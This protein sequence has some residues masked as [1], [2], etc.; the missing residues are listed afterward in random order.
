[1]PAG[2]PADVRLRGELRWGLELARLV[3]DPGFLRPARALDAPPVLLIPGFMAGD[4]SLAVLGGWL[5]KRGCATEAAGILLNMGCAE[6]VVARIETRLVRL[7]ERTGRR[8]V[9]VGQSRGGELARVIAVR[10]P[11]L[12][13]AL[14]MLGSPVLDPLDVGPITLAAVRWVARLGDVGVPGLFSNG[15]G[16]GECCARFREELV[17]PL[18]PAVRA[19]SIYSRSDGIVSWTACLD[20]YATTVEVESSHTGMAVNREVYHLLAGILDGH[21]PAPAAPAQ[22]A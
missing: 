8:V 5:R 20:P 6:R 9:L 13:D 3:A 15:C 2:E 22:A 11:D 16:F 19:T 18:P 14:V 4:Q 21:P 10:R 1:M 7:A 12:V 17:A